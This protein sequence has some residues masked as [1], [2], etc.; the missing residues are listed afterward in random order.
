GG[1]GAGAPH[2]TGR[3]EQQM[4]RRDFIAGSAGLLFSRW[5]SLPL[6]GAV[7]PVHY[8]KASPYESLARFIEAGNDE[9][10]GEP[11]AL[12]LE[13]RLTRMFQ[14]KEALPAGLAEWKSKLGEIRAARFFVLPEDRVRYEIATSTGKGLEYHTGLWKT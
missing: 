11:A 13:A 8:R 10:K 14:G 4:R 7:F 9:F 2:A 5:A 12:A 1:R 6:A 3:C